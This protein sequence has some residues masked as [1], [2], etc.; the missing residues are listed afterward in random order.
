MKSNRVKILFLLPALLCGFAWTFSIENPDAK[1]IIRRAEDK[2][3][4]TSSEASMS[5][6]IVRPKWERTLDFKTWSK[7]TEL[8]MILITGPA[9]DKGTAFLKKGKEVWN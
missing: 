9:R 4:G 2:L 6:T 8:A 3:R 1:E 5:M 7:G